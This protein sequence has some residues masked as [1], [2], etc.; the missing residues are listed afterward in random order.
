MLKPVIGNYQKYFDALF[1]KIRNETL[2]HLTRQ[3][4]CERHF[5]PSIAAAPQTV[6]KEV[7]LLIGGSDH[8]DFLVHHYL[9]GVIRAL[10]FDRPD[11]TDMMLEYRAGNKH[12]T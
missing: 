4:L 8:A 11:Q 1:M 10:S 9:Q 5:S 3:E 6:L 7:Y 2:I 12:A